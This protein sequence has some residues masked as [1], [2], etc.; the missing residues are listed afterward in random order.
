MPVTHHV[1]TTP[2]TCY[3]LHLLPVSRYVIRYTLCLLHTTSCACYTLHPVSVTHYTRCLLH[4]VDDKYYAKY[5]HLIDRLVQQVVLQQSD[6]TD[7]D[8]TPLKIDVDSLVQQ[9]VCCVCV[10]V[11]ACVCVCMRVRVCARAYVCA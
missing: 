11:C 2:C 3:T 5:W 10:C 8:V 1:H 7:P 9:Y 6:G 4:T